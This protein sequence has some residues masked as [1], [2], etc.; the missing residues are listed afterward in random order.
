MFVE[1]CV[2]AIPCEEQ[3]RVYSP[4]CGVDLQLNY[5]ALE[6]CPEQNIS[7]LGRMPC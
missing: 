5:L 1:N 7:V 6:E 4:F 3:Q 2:A